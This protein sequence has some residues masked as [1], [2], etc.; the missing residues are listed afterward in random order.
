MSFWSGQVWRRICCS[1]DLVTERIVVV[2]DVR[3]HIDDKQEMW[4]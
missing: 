3:S 4:T 1:R 2:A